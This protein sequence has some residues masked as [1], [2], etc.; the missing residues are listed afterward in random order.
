MADEIS[1][2][3]G[4]LFVRIT[5]DSREVNKQLNDLTRSLKNVQSISDKTTD[6]VN[7]LDESVDDLSE[8]ARSAKGDVDSL[9]NS[10]KGTG[11]SADNA[12]GKTDTF[13][14]SLDD[15]A[16]A[17][18]NAADEVNGLGDETEKHGDKTEDAADAQDNFTDSLGDTEIAGFKAAAAIGA[19]A[20]ALGLIYDNAI[21][22]YEAVE[23]ARKILRFGTNA[24]AT[25]LDELVG[26]YDRVNTKVTQSNEEVAEAVSDLNTYYGVTGQ[27][28]ED[29]SIAYLN[30]AKVTGSNV[31]QVIE[32]AHDVFRKYGIGVDEQAQKL[33]EFYDICAGSKLSASELFGALKSEKV[34]FD[35]LGMSIDDAAAM[36]ATGK[37]NEGIE[38]TTKLVAGVQN[39]ISKAYDSLNSQADGTKSKL[40]DLVSEVRNARDDIEG[41]K[42]LTDS[43]LILG[44]DAEKLT[45]VIRSESDDYDKFAD[46]VRRDND[47]MQTSIGRLLSTARKSL[48]GDTYRDLFVPSTKTTKEAEAAVRN[49][50][51]QIRDAASD[52]EA[53]AVAADSGFFNDKEIPEFVASVRSGTLAYDRFAQDVKKDN[54]SIQDA[55]NETITTQDKMTIAG[56]KINDIFEPLGKT[57]CDMFDELEPLILACA[58]GLEWILRPKD[59]GGLTDLLTMFNPFLHVISVV[60][61]WM[62]DNK[63]RIMSVLDKLWSKLQVIFSDTRLMEFLDNLWGFIDSKL[64]VVLDLTLTAVDK[65]I[66][67]IFG[68]GGTENGSIFDG[69]FAIVDAM[70]SAFKEARLFTAEVFEAILKIILEFLI[71]AGLSIERG[72]NTF[73][74]FVESSLNAMLQ[75]TGMIANGIIDVIDSAVNLAIDAINRLIDAWNMVASVVGGPILSY[76]EHVSLG[77]V[78]VPTVELKRSTLIS[79]A[80]AGLNEALGVVLEAKG[81]NVTINQTINASDTDS[82]GD[83]AAKAS[84]A[85]VRT[86]ISGAGMG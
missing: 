57:L 62:R 69:I 53:R 44:I 81:G 14:D 32:Q 67:V 65:L 17:A 18:D 66:D 83:I 13:S 79:D 38:S 63:D 10:V 40:I 20:A 8:T 2:I 37:L 21:K 50:M 46:A 1:A 4:N 35:L 29:L 41:E 70:M 82:A 58:R 56:K 25:G 51:E 27:E 80:V 48:G 77:E 23:N 64:I 68:D 3:A 6:K 28:L 22:A 12:A 26:V 73:L 42:I 85:I 39:A 19:A 86:G 16:Q 15:E 78:S 47:L 7:D 75:F 33:E 49:V 54:T 34:G 72:F 74:T 61:D 36:L 30:F 71:T 24:T 76:I 55:I 45:R 60:S 43:G 59:K 52:E 11:D 84:R 9:T 31:T 5:A